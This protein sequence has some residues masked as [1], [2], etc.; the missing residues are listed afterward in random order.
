MTY[1]DKASCGSL[2]PCTHMRET[3]QGELGEAHTYTTTMFLPPHTHAHIRT[4][5]HAFF[6]PHTHT[7]THTHVEYKKKKTS[8]SLEGSLPFCTSQICTN[9]M[10]WRTHMQRGWVRIYER[11]YENNTTR[12]KLLVL[13]TV[14]RIQ[15]V[16]KMERPVKKRN[17]MTRMSHTRLKHSHSNGIH[18]TETPQTGT[19]YTETPQNVTHY[20]ETP[21]NGT[22]YTETPQIHS[23]ATKTWFKQHTSQTNACSFFVREAYPKIFR[24]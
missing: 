24:K 19:H 23:H 5:T 8:S 7:H 3:L 1:K 16:W 13:L 11:N 12:A 15:D 20:T 22:H 10:K 18:Y 17:D 6:L 2:P 14:S 4:N 9:E 21:Q